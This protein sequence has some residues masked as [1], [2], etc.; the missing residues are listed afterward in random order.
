MNPADVT[1]AYAKG[2]RMG[3]ATIL[4]HL[5]VTKIVVENGRAA[6]GDDR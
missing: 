6:G 1:M 4:E 2:A 3:G 5:A